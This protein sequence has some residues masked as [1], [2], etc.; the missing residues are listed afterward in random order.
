MKK[1]EIIRTLEEMFLVAT[2]R[3]PKEIR[4]YREALNE[5]I[6]AIER[7]ES[8][9]PLENTWTSSET[10]KKNTSYWC[11]NCGKYVSRVYEKDNYCRRCG[12]KIERGN[13]DYGFRE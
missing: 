11:G 13:N 9:E 8:Y 4:P 10:G 7:A 3:Y 1:E 2:E 6:K 12:C 5:A